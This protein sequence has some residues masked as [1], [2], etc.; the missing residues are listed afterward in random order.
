MTR[1]G[2]HQGAQKST[3]T[4]TVCDLSS[5]PYVDV[6]GARMLADLQ[7]AWAIQGIQ[8]QLAEGDVDINR[9]FNIQ[10]FKTQ[11]EESAAQA[12]GDVA[13]SLIAIYRA[14]GGGWPAQGLGEPVPVPPAPEEGEESEDA[15][16]ELLEEPPM[17]EEELTLPEGVTPE[18]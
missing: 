14:V 4:G 3:T 7:E 9:V 2:P 11:Q 16:E 8:L 13:Q 5:T 6:T 15:A 12:R 1:H 10:N 17:L 18:E